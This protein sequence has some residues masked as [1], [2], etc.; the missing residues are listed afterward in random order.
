MAFDW[1][2]LIGGIAPT[3]ATALGGP[4][5]GMA[6][7]ELSSGLLGKPDGT[8][9]EISKALQ[10]ASPDTFL[11]IKEIDAA[12][13]TKMVDAGIDLEKIAAADRDSARSREA[14][15][16]DLTPRILAAVTVTGFFLVVGWVLSGRVS[17]ESTLLGFVL[18]QVSTKAEQVY[19]YYFGSSSGSDKKTHLLSGKS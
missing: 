5:A 9:Q 17:L 19:N 14:N 7:K 3:I 4:L 2:V 16:K 8:E 13:N 18:G 15:L 11:K 10:A 1:K 12:F 6:V